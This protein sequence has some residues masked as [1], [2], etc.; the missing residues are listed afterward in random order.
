MKTTQLI[1][2]AFFATAVFS[3]SALA[4]G[5]IWKYGGNYGFG[6]GVGAVADYKTQAEAD[7]TAIAQ[8]KKERPAYAARS[9]WGKCRI[10]EQFSDECVA[11]SRFIIKGTRRVPNAGDSNATAPTVTEDHSS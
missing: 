7:R 10:V 4:F 11:Y 2:A 6:R 9:K 5:A 3:Q 1:L 8:C